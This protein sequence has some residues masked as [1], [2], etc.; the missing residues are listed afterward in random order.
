MFRF[1]IRDMLWLTVVVAVSF[2]WLV[3]RGLNGTKLLWQSRAE[4]LR[5]ICQEYGWTVEWQGGGVNGAFP[6]L[7][8][9]EATP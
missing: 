2:G 1:T 9:P 8:A 4:H 7:D 6:P 5:S 3:D